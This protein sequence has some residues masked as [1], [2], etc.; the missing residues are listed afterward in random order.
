LSAS[1]STDARFEISIRVEG[2]LVV[3]TESGMYRRITTFSMGII[4]EY[5]E[6]S[7]Q[8]RLEGIHPRGIVITI[9]SARTKLTT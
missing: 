7:I 3:E 1:E 9:S 8:A 4:P 5:L 2:L 6:R